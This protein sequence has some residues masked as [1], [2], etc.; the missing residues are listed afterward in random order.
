MA[1]FKYVLLAAWPSL[2]WAARCTSSSSTITVFHGPKVETRP[3]WFCEAT[4]DAEYNAGDFDLTDL[5]F[6]SGGRVRE[7][8]VLF[9]SSGTT[10]DRLQ[11][12]ADEEGVWISNSLACLMAVTE[13]T[14]AAT[15]TSY[16]EKLG[17]IVKGLG[18]YEQEL[19]AS[20]G[21]VQFTY[22]NNL[23][24]DGT[25]LQEV[26]KPDTQRD[27]GNFTS[28]R[29]F[30]QTSLQQVRE[31]MEAAGRQHPYQLLGT[32]SSGYDS[33]TNTVLA[34]KAGLQEVLSF[35]NARGG[36]ADDGEA[37]AAIL[38]IKLT[39][40]PRNAWQAESLAEVPF[41][42][43][44]AKGEDVYF[45]GVKAL[46][47]GR[48]LLTGFHGDK[49][50]AKGTTKL[51]AS[52]SRGD[53][54]GLSLTE[55]RLWAGFLHLPLPFMGVRQIRDINAISNSPEMKPWDIP[56][57]YSRPICRRIV[58]EAGVPRNMFGMSKK[59]AS[60]LFGSKSD[61]LMPA[62]RQAFYE[63]LHAHDAEWLS[64]AKKPPLASGNMV[65]RFAAP[66][67][68]VKRAVNMLSK[69]APK[70]MQGSAKRLKQQLE[71]LERQQDPLTYV[72]PWAIEKAKERYSAYHAYKK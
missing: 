65:E 38:G 66:F 18:K 20:A 62:T 48:V 3:A 71:H 41:I 46:L 53:R 40:A 69:K 52:I 54:S 57:N 25:T 30:L 16:F 26:E 64:K 5:V 44:D 15:D 8:Q 33:T 31:N 68:L 22:F 70:P 43:A 10:V 39:L 2:A 61:A 67:A 21:K 45:G 72:F 35:S 34:Q 51:D 23:K 9:V 24:W 32:L 58:E 14:F 6:G 59:A 47:G 42:A 12:L 13:A 50:W 4:W 55:Y 17:S 27:F 49:V 36:N 29:N 63:W 11:S 7:E 56:G 19:A 28:Y 37:I 60:V 1:N